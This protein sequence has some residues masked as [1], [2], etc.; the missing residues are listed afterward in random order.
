MEPVSKKSI[1][2]GV[3]L[4]PLT[5]FVLLICTLF[6]CY[7][8]EI[9]NFNLTIDEELHLGYR[10]AIVDWIGEGRWGMYLLSFF[11]PTTIV[12]VVSVFIGLV[13]MLISFWFL[14]TKIFDLDNLSA[15][16]AVSLAITVPSLFFIFMFS[17]IA[18]AIGI[19]YLCILLVAHFLLRG[20]KTDLV[21]AGLIGSFSIAIYQP[22]FILILIIIIAVWVYCPDEQ[23]FR[24]IKNGLIVFII[25]LP[26]YF[27]INRLFSFLLEDQNTLSYV[28][29][30][31]NFEFGAILRSVHKS[32]DIFWDIITL[33]EKKFGIHHPW[34]AILYLLTIG[35]TIYSVLVNSKKYKIVRI[36]FIVCISLVPIVTLFLIPKTPIRSQIYLPF[37]VL[38]FTG[39]SFPVLKSWLKLVF[40]VLILI[41]II[42]NSVVT[43]YLIASSIVSYELD[44]KLAAEISH[45]LEYKFKIDDKKTYDLEVVGV[46]T[47]FTHEFEINTEVVGRS[48][49]QFHQGDP[50]RVAAFLRIHGVPV[51]AASDARRLELK[52]FATRMPVYPEDGWIQLYENTIILKFGHYSRVQRQLFRTKPAGKE[53]RENN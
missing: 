17:T 53:S 34:L 18:Y 45:E 41:A 16:L 26:A 12:P 25:S 38:I 22:F 44:S 50:Y 42:N 43:N 10:N 24:R 7:G 37:I 3:V 30:H 51:E 28:F 35:I 33:D 4:S 9:F 39:M 47:P 36:F 19:G 13:V 46:K 2:K 27:I 21:I 31:V 14:M 5:P 48:F 40:A 32:W 15:S 6:L 8:Y 20:G 23:L 49:F 1:S 52:P 11:I 29:K